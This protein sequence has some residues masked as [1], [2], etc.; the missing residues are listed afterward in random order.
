MNDPEF[1]FVYGTLR[2]G[3]QNPFASYL[4]QNAVYKGTGTFAGRLYNL[5][6]YPGAVYDTQSSHQ[7]VGEIYELKNA[8]LILKKLDDYEGIN[9]PL[10]EY[11]RQKIE[12]QSE[13]GELVDCWIYLF[14]L[15]THGLQLIAEGDYTKWRDNNLPL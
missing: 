9:E 10:P 2:Q 14:I 1:L 4:R 11:K 15:P 12:V 5:G 6:H 8:A 7:V 3:F 13:T